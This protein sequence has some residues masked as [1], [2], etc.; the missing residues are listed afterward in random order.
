MPCWQTWFQ[1]SCRTLFVYGCCVDWGST[2]PTEIF[3]MFHRGSATAIEPM[4]FGLGRR[5]SRLEESPESTQVLQL[6]SRSVPVLGRDFDEARAVSAESGGGTSLYDVSVP[7]GSPMA[8]QR[9]GSAGTSPESWRSAPRFGRYL[10]VLSPI[11][12]A[13]GFRPGPERLGAGHP[14]S[15]SRTR[16]S[17]D[18]VFRQTP[19]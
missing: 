12:V 9:C 3:G 7:W 17:P 15:A 1:V 2:V 18:N 10:V 5:A 14:K 4:K 8:A 16:P 11:E 13:D 19:S 6:R